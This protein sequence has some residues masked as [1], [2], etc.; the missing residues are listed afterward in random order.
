MT[1]GRRRKGEGEDWHRHGRGGHLP[2]ANLVHVVE[3]KDHELVGLRALRL[4]RAVGLWRYGDAVVEVPPVDVV[5]QSLCPEEACRPLILSA[6]T[7]LLRCHDSRCWVLT[8]GVAPQFLQSIACGLTP[9]SQ[10]LWTLPSQRPSQQSSSRELPERQ[11]LRLPLMHR[12][13]LISQPRQAAAQMSVLARLGVPRAQERSSPSPQHPYHPAQAS[14]C[15]L[16]SPGNQEDWVK[17]GTVNGESVASTHV[18]AVS[19]TSSVFPA[20]LRGEETIPPPLKACT[21]NTLSMNALFAN[22]LTI[23]RP[24][25]L[26]CVKRRA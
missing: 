2:G 6:A 9:E 11:G 10:I 15:S 14:P 4:E 3:M 12:P 1:G 7:S 17:R 5:M 21:A 13:G 16:R 19:G 20:A 22:G 23:L 18:R 26:V 8:A 24:L 25:Y